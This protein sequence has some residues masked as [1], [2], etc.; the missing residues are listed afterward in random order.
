MRITVAKFIA[1]ITAIVVILTG[2]IML[3]N[4]T[5]ISTEPDQVGLW[6]KAGPLTSTHFD[7]CVDPGTR[8]LFGGLDDNTYTYPAGIRTYEFHSGG[9]QDVAPVK[10]LT[11]DNLELTVSGVVR[12]QLNT[13]CKVLQ[14]FHEQI[15]LKTNSF[16][17]GDKTSDGWNTMLA[18]FLQQSLQR[19]VNEAT[20]DFNWK[21]LY[22]STEVKAS[23]EKKVAELLPTYVK[24]GMGDEYFDNYSLTIQKPELPTALLQALQDTQTAVE[25]NNAQKQRNTQVETEIQS[26]AKLVAILGPEGYNT[27][28][29]IKD[30]KINVMPIP[31]GSS[32]NVT[33]PVPAA[34]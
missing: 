13:D 12:F 26:I 11:K 16:M 28:Q 33:S 3:F 1:G 25:Q 2:V 8:Q 27:Y 30:G 19:A 17:N 20:Q 5:S 23:W 32:F 22:S 7:H 4:V 29:A 34:K 10:A 24:Q 14:K 31:Q 21:D 15:G 18:T 6:Y 9:S